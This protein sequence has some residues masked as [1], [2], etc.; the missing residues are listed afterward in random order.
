VKDSA[1]AALIGFV[2]VAAFRA[3]DYLFPRGRHWTFVERFTT[4]NTTE[5][6]NDEAHEERVDDYE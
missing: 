5:D 6:E 3:L 2:S 4:A 1:W